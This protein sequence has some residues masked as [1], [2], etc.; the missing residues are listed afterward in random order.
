MKNQLDEVIEDTLG[1]SLYAFGILTGL[2][3]KYGRQ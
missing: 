3:K 1:E 2:L